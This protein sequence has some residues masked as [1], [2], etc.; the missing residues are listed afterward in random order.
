ME[1]L[2]ALE[3]AI[4]NGY[5][6]KIKF[7]FEGEYLQSVGSQRNSFSNYDDALEWAKDYAPEYAQQLADHV[8]VDSYSIRIG[9]NN[10]IVYSNAGT[11]S[12]ED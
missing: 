12:L 7:Y 4:T 9:N 3:G 2:P 10:S 1:H 6:A 11:F 8:N 5:S